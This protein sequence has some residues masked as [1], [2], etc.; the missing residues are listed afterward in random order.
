MKEFLSNSWV[1]SIISG[2]IVFFLTNAIIMI[3]N[4][5]KHQKQI[6]DANT[7]A[8]NR[9]R[10]YVV[11]NGL[12]PKEIINAI[13]SSTSREHD[14][15]FEELL[16][17]EEICEELITDIISNIYISNENKIRYVNMLQN[18][19]KENTDSH[20]IKTKDNDENEKNSDDTKQNI[21]YLKKTVERELK[22]E[23][24]RELKRRLVKKSSLSFGMI[25]S[26]LLAVLSAISVFASYINLEYLVS[27]FG[28]EIIT[29]LL[30]VLLI[31]PFIEKVIE[32]FTKK[33]DK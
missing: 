1:V 5:R 6:S 18:Y 10:G 4:R 27:N 2:I 9:L 20:D 19:L 30:L 11:D 22:R 28:F 14:I 16:S 12:P 29:V 26:I 8:L 13:K 7:M 3:Q 23:L 21:T 17:V 31:N 24:E 15:K 25:I 33:R 32:F